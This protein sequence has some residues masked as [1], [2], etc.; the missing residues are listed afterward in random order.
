MAKIDLMTVE[1]EDGTL[2]FDGDM[3]MGDLRKLLKAG[4]EGDLTVMVEAF[5][6]IVHGWPYDGEP[7]DP[8]AWDNLRRSQFGRLTTALMGKLGEQ[9]EA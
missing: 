1:F 6:Q 4:T 9:G 2:T 8:D 3:R 5:T 7:S